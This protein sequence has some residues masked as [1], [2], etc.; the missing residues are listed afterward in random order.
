MK[1]SKHTMLS[2]FIL[3]S[4]KDKSDKVSKPSKSKKKAAPYKSA[5]DI[6]N[7][8]HEESEVEFKETKVGKIKQ[9]IEDLKAQMKQRIDSPVSGNV[10]S[11][12]ADYKYFLKQIEELEAELEKIDGVQDK[13]KATITSTPSNVDNLEGDEEG[14]KTETDESFTNPVNVI[15]SL[16]K[17]HSPADLRNALKY[18]QSHDEFK[19]KIKNIEDK[20]SK[21]TNKSS[22]VNENEETLNEDLKRLFQLRAGIKK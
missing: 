21:V 11:V 19:D 6:M 17:D 15:N 8:I 9:A 10:D 7:S 18:A 1:K 12:H 14:E 3:E 5:K 22:Q 13:P 2:D 16:D 4:A 20:I